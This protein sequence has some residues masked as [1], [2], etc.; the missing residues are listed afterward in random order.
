MEGDLEKILLRSFSPTLRPISWDIKHGEKIVPFEEQRVEN[1]TLAGE[2]KIYYL[3]CWQRKKNISIYQKWPRAG[4]HFNKIHTNTLAFHSALSGQ[5]CPTSTWIKPPGSTSKTRRYKII[6]DEGKICIWWRGFTLDWAATTCRGPRDTCDVSLA[7]R[8][9]FQSGRLTVG[10]RLSQTPTAP[11]C[12][13]T[14]DFYALLWRTSDSNTQRRISLAN[15]VSVHFITPLLPCP[16]A[17]PLADASLLCESTP[18]ISLS[19][20]LN[21]GNICHV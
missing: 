5:S 7:R 3:G 21:P 20:N 1:W 4:V 6:F 16:P 2:H 15:K 18:G 12:V 11:T 19:N 10:P 8:R 17:L 9:L 14:P 13:N